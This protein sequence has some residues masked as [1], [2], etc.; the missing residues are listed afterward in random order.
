VEDVCDRIAILYN[1][2]IQATGQMRDMLEEK[3]RHQ[4]TLPDLP[5]ETIKETLNKLRQLL[6]AEPELSHPRK[7]LE[8]FF[9]DVI[10]KAR[11]GA[12][13][14]SGATPVDAIGGFLSDRGGKSGEKD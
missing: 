2:E 10:A 13:T 5:K 3:D 14:D 1:G 4:I 11:D 7:N 12:V 6:G 9:L 8:Q